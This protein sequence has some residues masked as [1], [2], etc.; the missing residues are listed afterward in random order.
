MCANFKII[1]IGTDKKDAITTHNA[2]VG[3]IEGYQQTGNMEGIFTH[4]IYNADFKNL[5]LASAEDSMRSVAQQK[6]MK[7]KKLVTVNNN[8]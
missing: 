8:Y 1:I 6:K 3:N 2:T 7:E 4:I 5:L